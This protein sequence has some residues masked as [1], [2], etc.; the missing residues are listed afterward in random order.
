MEPSPKTLAYF[1]NEAVIQ[2]GFICFFAVAFPLAPI[3]SFFTNLL[4]LKL[5]L[6]L[7]TKYGRR[8]QAVGSNGIGNWKDVMSF[9]TFI[10]VPINLSVL[11]YARNPGEKEVGAL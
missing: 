10:A 8:N 6:K 4:S 2:M 9:V 5:K 7:M 11:I 3:F 1:Y